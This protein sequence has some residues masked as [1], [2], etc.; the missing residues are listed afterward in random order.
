MFWAVA[1]ANPLKCMHTSGSAIRP[2]KVKRSVLLYRCKGLGDS[3]LHLFDCRR[4][5]SLQQQVHKATLCRSTLVNCVR[6]LSCSLT[7][8]P[9]AGSACA[10]LPSSRTLFTL[11]TA[12]SPYSSARC[13]AFLTD[14]P[15]NFLNCVLV[16][17]METAEYNIGCVPSRGKRQTPTA[18]DF[19]TFSVSVS[20]RPCL[21]EEPEPC[22]RRRTALH[23]S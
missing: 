14:F 6:V 13:L 7:E 16:G 9:N 4:L 5:C 19:L 23:R 2:E 3:L 15:R 11:F 8:G 21:P 12:F 20:L 10:P 22:R 18:G 17:N 1:T